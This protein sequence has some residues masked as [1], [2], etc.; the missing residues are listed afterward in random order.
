MVCAAPVRVSFD[1]T[2]AATTVA[3]VEIDNP[4]VNATSTAVRA[5]LELA[6]TAIEQSKASVAILTCAGRTFVAGGDMSEFDAAPKTPHLPDVVTNIEG[7]SVPW[8]AAMHGTVLGGGFELAMG[9]AYRIAAAG[10]QFGLPEVSVGL[11]PGAGGT[12]RL[13]RLVPMEVAIDITCRGQKVS[14]QALLD[15]GAIDAISDGDLRADALAFARALAPRPEA[16]S[17]RSASTLPSALLDAERAKIAA[18][19]KGQ[20]SPLLNLEALSWSALPFAEGQPKERTLHL[21]LRNSAESRALRHAFFAEREVGRP[22]VIEGVQ[23]R[24]LEKIVVVGGGLMGAGIASAVLGAG[25]AVTIIERDAEAAAAAQARV[26]SN[27]DGALKRGKVTESVFER[28]KERLISASDYTAAAGHD[29]AIEAVFEDVGVKRG[30]FQQLAA[31]MTDDAILATN[32]SYLDP[33][34]IFAGIEGPE[35]CIGL[36]FFSPAHIMKLLEVVRLPGTGARTLATG[37]AFGKRLRKVAVL[38]GICDGFIGN[39]MLAAYRREAEYMLVDGA[40]PYQIDAAMRGFGYAMG[41]FEAQ[42]MSGLQIGWANRKA[43]ASHR[44]PLQRYVFIADELCEAERLGQRSGKGWYDYPGES[45]KP[46]RASEVESLIETHSLSQGIAR[47]DY[48]DDEIVERL[49]AVLV[50]EGL[51]IVEEGIAENNA[52]V[53]MVQIHGYGFPRWR[54]GPMQYANEIG[55]ERIAKTMERVEIESPESWTVAKKLRN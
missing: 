23:G 14:A 20:G 15:L 1:D 38:A 55:L 7:S 33:A 37:F 4:P 28:Q 52:A 18:R 54:G 3:W 47:I 49:L 29:L 12:Q 45:R 41:P 22:Q 42:D 27:L 10:T 2:V 19:A 26:L 35:R 5:S 21:D 9:C 46:Q 51:L 48:S 25:Y 39:R 11:V 16:V 32:T 36:H 40:L 43:Q 50:N 44:D 17:Q 53:D 31:V 8:I 13:P 30:V 34:E 24:K 6:I